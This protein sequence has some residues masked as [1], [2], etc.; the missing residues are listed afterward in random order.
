[1]LY[2]HIYFRNMKTRNLNIDLIKIVAM[3]GVLSL[4]C[5][6]HYQ[7]S[8]L[9]CLLFKSAVFSIPLFFMVSG[10]LMASKSNIDYRYCW[11]KILG[12]LKFSIGISLP[13]CLLQAVVKDS[14]DI[15][16]IVRSVI[17]NYFQLPGG[18]FG[19]FWYFGA[20]II[21][22]AFLPLISRLFKYKKIHILLMSGGGISTNGVCTKSFSRN[23]I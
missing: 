23:A 18:R 10:Y 12:I 17:G 7:S 14:F 8:I 20:M 13:F 4:H 3:F 9:A 2:T 1:M 15:I 5:N 11:R 6:V 21:I 16:S 19:V 22:Y